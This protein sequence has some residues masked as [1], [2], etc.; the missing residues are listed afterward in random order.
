LIIPIN[1]SGQTC[2]R[3]LLIEG[4][5]SLLRALKPA[6]EEVDVAVDVAAHGGE[7]GQKV[8]DGEYDVIVASLQLPD[9]DWLSLLQQLRQTEGT[10]SFLFVV[11]GTDIHERFA[12]QSHPHPNAPPTDVTDVQEVLAQIAHL[13]RQRRLP[14]NQALVVEDLEINPAT[15]S[16]RR[17]GKP[18]HLT[19][20]EFELLHLLAAHRGKVVSRSLI[21]EHLYHENDEAT[22]NVVDVYIRHLRS[23]LDKGFDP[24]L[25]LTRWGEGYMIRGEE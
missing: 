21:W 2:V 17:Q 7:A 6:L 16:V 8:Q 19:P 15:R 18:I 4:N 14:R 12:T 10:K 3:V 1:T 11:T 23:K 24:P 5:R 25:I 22:S 20:R 13:V 9:S